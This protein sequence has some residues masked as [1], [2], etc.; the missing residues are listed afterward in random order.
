MYPYKIWVFRVLCTQ[1]LWEGELNLQRGRHAWE[2]RR[3][4][5]L[6]TLLIPE[7]NTKCHLEHSCM[8][9]PRKGGADL[10]GCCGRR[11]LISNTPWANLS[12][13]TTGKTNFSAASDLPGE[14]KTQVHRNSWRRVDKKNYTPESR[15]LCPHNWLKGNRKTGLQHYW[16]TGE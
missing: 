4:C 9:A 11:E 10:P 8:V 5:T 7:E 15:K 1:I 14:L 2:T 12:L 6:H 16:N 13:W 3:D